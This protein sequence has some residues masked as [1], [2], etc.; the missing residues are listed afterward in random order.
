MSYNQINGDSSTITA[1]KNIKINNLRCN[2]LNLLGGNANPTTETV[3]VKFETGANNTLVDLVFT[4]IGDIIICKIP[5]FNLLGDGIN[6]NA[7]TEEPLPEKYRVTADTSILVYFENYS[8]NEVNIPLVLRSD[9]KLIYKDLSTGTMLGSSLIDNY[10]I[11]IK[12]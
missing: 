5:I 4:N 10:F 3:E 12:N 1:W 9:G 2:Q 6:G 11:Y 8:G 7:V